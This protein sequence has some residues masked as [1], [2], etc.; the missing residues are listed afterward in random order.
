MRR[1]DA[2]GNT[3]TRERSGDVELRIGCDTL[4][5]L[6]QVA[7]GMSVEEVYA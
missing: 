4:D 1:L 2:V 6:L 5:Q 7:T 3:T